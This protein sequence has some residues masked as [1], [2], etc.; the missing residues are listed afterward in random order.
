MAVGKATS[1]VGK[2]GSMLNFLPNPLRFARQMR[3]R[4]AGAQA[5]NATIHMAENI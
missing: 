5:S 4:T 2:L 3:Q 1:S